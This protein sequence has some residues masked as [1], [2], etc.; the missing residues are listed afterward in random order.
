MLERTLSFLGIAWL[1]A[2]LAGTMS[3]SATA[4]PSSPAQAPRIRHVFIIV[5]ENKNY[6]DTFKTSAQDP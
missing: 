6:D 3:G 4:A 5:L 1:T 2:A